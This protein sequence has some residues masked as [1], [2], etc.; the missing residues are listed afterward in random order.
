M[1]LQAVVL[2]LVSFQGAYSISLKGIQ[3]GFGGI[4][5]GFNDGF[6]GIGVSNIIK[7]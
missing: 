5:D 1:R 3:D 7:N 6:G 2:A 4:Q